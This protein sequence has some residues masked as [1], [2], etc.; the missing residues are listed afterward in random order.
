MA[1]MQRNNKIRAAAILVAVF[2]LGGVTGAGIMRWQLMDEL[3][4]TMKL[5]PHEARAKFRLRAMR[6]HLDL[7]DEQA[8]KI[9]SILVESDRGR[10]EAEAPCR[11]KLDEHREKVR[12]RIDEVLTPEQRQAYAEMRARW[13]QKRKEDK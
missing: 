12:Q 8:A 2:A 4:S 9:E 6:R 3:H 1:E 5:P 7:S 11:G 10:G 13:E